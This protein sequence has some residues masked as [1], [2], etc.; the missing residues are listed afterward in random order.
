MSDTL[1]LERGTP[2]QAGAIR[3][4]TLRAY[5]KWVPVIQRKPRPMT[6]DYDL[7]LREHR[8]DCLWDGDALIGLIETIEQDDELLIVNV[9]IDPAWQGRGL[10]VRLMRHAEDIARGAGLSGTRLYTNTLMAANIALYAAL[11]YSVEKETRPGQGVVVVHMTR[12]L[13]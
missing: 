3:D 11:G 4:M 9:A 2:D 13:G 5:A 1:R 6:A 10:G 12:A 8:F 7:A